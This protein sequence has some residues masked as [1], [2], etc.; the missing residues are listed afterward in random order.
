[1]KMRMVPMRISA[2]ASCSKREVSQ[3][4][5]SRKPKRGKQEPNNLGIS[6]YE[7]WILV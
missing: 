2:Q 7:I 4:W 1:M 6:L 3:G 5:I